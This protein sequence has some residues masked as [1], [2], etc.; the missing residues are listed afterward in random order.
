MV[1]EN[2]MGAYDE[3]EDGTSTTATASPTCEPHQAMGEAINDGVDLIAYT[4]G[5]PSIWWCRRYR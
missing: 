3:K 5:A 2:G 1:V 4:G